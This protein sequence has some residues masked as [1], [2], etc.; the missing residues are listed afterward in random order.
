MSTKYYI[1]PIN[2]HHSHEHADLVSQNYH[3]GL[4]T[5]AT[6]AE[7]PRQYE[8]K[9]STKVEAKRLKAKLEKPVKAS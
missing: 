2:A 6:P 9:A 7:S 1:H 3:F 5:K 8:H 4:W